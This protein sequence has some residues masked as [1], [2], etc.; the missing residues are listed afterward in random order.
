MFYLGTPRCFGRCPCVGD[1]HARAFR[2]NGRRFA[3]QLLSSDSE[4]K[5]GVMSW[6]LH[7]E[8]GGPRAEGEVGSGV[9]EIQC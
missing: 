5:T 2:H 6:Y 3:C 7:R 8:R 1:T 4:K 9:N